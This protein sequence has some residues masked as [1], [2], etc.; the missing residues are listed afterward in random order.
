MSAE[1]LNGCLR[2]VGEDPVLQGQ[3]MASDALAAAG[4][5]PCEGFDVVVADFAR[6]KARS[7]SWRLS[8]EE[9][10]VV[11]R[12]QALAQAYWWQHIWPGHGLQ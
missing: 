10:D 12:W 9:F 3:L 7:T 4:L 6:H 11:A 5:A 8:D 1:Q 2:R